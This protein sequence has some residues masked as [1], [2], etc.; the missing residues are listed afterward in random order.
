[1]SY[2]LTLL[3]RTGFTIDQTVQHVRE[4]EG[5]AVEL[6]PASQKRHRSGGGPPVV[7]VTSGTIVTG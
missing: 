2:Y 6:M 3:N 5:L 7:A 4:A 1:M